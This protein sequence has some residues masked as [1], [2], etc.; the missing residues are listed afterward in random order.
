MLNSISMAWE[1]ISNNKLY[2]FLKPKLLY[3]YQSCL[4]RGY[5]TVI[6]FFHLH[7]TILKQLS[8]GN[9]VIVLFV[10][11]SKAFDTVQHKILINTMKNMNI[12]GMALKVKWLIFYLSDREQSTYYNN[13]YSTLHGALG[14]VYIHS[15]Q[16]QSPTKLQPKLICRR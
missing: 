7:E 2:S 1:R 14:V 5:L 4:W 6:G 8:Q 15:R 3:K 11:M 12:K 9:H 13:H 16:P 10:N